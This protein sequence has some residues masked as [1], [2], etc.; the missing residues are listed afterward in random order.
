MVPHIQVHVRRFR[1]LVLGW[2]GLEEELLS[3]FHVTRN[4]GDPLL[5]LELPSKSSVLK[6]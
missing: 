3:G 2:C 1:R 5:D 4:V 6:C